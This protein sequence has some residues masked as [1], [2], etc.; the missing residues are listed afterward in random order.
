MPLSPTLAAWL[1]DRGHD[2]VH[3]GDVG[4]H[5]RDRCCDLGAGEARRWVSAV[6]GTSNDKPQHRRVTH[7]SAAAPGTVGYAAGAVPAERSC[8]E[9]PLTQLSRPPPCRQSAS[10]VLDGV[11]AVIRST[12]R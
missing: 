12:P 6:H 9:A 4:L 8:R 7:H 5:C 11:A 2:A 1:T 3:A 10:Q